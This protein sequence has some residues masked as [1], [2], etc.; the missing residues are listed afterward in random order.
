MAAG[1]ERHLTI[2]G[3]YAEAFA[4]VERAVTAAGA[5]MTARDPAAG[6]LEGVR[7]EHWLAP[8]DTITVTLTPVAGGVDV[9]LAG[10]PPA[11]EVL[12]WGRNERTLDLIARALAADTPPP[13]RPARTPPQIERPAAGTAAAIT[14]A[15]PPAIPTP[16]A[17][18]KPS[19]ETV[20]PA[21]HFPPAPA[22]P[23][24]TGPSPLAGAPPV[25]AR[26]ARPAPTPTG[27]PAR[28]APRPPA[29]PRGTPVTGRTA[30]SPAG[31]ALTVTGASTPPQDTLDTA[32]ADAGG[33]CWETGCVARA[34]GRCRVCLRRVCA[35]HGHRD[36]TGQTCA[37]C[38][39]EG[40]DAATAYTTWK[41]EVGL[42]HAYPWVAVGTALNA[43][44]LALVL[45]VMFGGAREALFLATVAFVAWGM[46]AGWWRADR[47]EAASP[48]R[49]KA[50]WL[51]A[52]P[53]LAVGYALLRVALTVTVVV[54][55][56]HPR[57]RAVAAV[58]RSA[59]ADVG[60][61]LRRGIAAAD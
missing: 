19:S 32:F 43:V 53:G 37:L 57:G 28:P 48:G 20:P 51:A 17:P 26:P 47:L 38:A 29:R 14:R 3:E 61:L 35:A 13:P 50:V 23:T 41:R 46:Y 7:Q 1:A 49:Q 4:V 24:S 18:A 10:R 6:R 5:R 44:L 8:T 40:A 27:P 15:Q 21:E 60:A 11:G 52:V 54:W 31:G 58:L 9:H 33:L 2:V 12:D 45:M 25:P 59:A 22:P 55:P 56:A 36:A 30:R 39:G 16:A 34:E 42:E